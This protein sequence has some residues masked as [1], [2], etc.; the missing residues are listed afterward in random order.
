MCD[1]NAFISEM[2]NDLKSE[3]NNVDASVK[4]INNIIKD[5]K[6]NISVIKE[7]IDTTYDVF[8]ASQ[9]NNNV[10]NTEIST[11]NNII[12]VRENERRD[13]ELRRDYINNRL[14]TIEGLKTQTLNVDID[15]L[16]FVLQLIDVDPYRAKCELKRLIKEL[17]G[18]E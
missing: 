4:R 3:L 15:K 13:L 10:E 12:E 2:E 8:S 14:N 11:F 1:L 7:S 16:D 17:R 9:M 18:K 6:N 5:A